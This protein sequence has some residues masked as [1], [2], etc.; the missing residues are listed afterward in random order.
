[1]NAAVLSVQSRRV[2]W[3]QPTMV[4]PEPKP[5][6]FVMSEEFIPVGTVSSSSIAIHY[7]RPGVL[8]QL[9]CYV[10]A[11]LA[12]SVLCGLALGWIGQRELVEGLGALIGLI[13]WASVR[14]RIGDE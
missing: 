9:R 2:R 3:F 7:E 6:L 13:V 11:A 14:R 12:G 10:G 5:S 8:H 1:V 4:S